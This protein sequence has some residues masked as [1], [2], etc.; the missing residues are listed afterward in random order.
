MGIK[1]LTFTRT[2][3]QSFPGG[4]LSAGIVSAPPDCTTVFMSTVTSGTITCWVRKN[5]KRKY[6]ILIIIEENCIQNI[7]IVCKVNKRY[8]GSF[9]ELN[10]C[11]ILWNGCRQRYSK[12][13]VNNY[14]EWVYTTIVMSSIQTQKV[15]ILLQE[16]QSNMPDIHN[17]QMKNELLVC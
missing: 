5:W 2:W 10:V 15:A 3:I 6:R 14:D 12:Q 11:A 7:I 9:S 17:C 1:Q 4:M 13:V 8:Y 16:D